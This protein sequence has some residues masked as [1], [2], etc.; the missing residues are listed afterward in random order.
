[1]KLPLQV[2]LPYLDPM[3]TNEH[4]I[5]DIERAQRAWE[6]ERT[7]WILP[8]ITETLRWTYPGNLSWN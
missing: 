4:V 5:R 3:A 2:W 6:G 8:G 1:M 7:I